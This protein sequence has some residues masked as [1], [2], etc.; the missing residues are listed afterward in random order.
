M[1]SSTI[2]NPSTDSGKD[3]NLA[4]NTTR[5]VSFA[6]LL[7]GEPIRKSINFRTLLAST[8]NG[9]DVSISMEWVRVVHERFSNIPIT[10]FT[11]EGFSAITTKL[12]TPLM[13]DAYTPAL[14]AE[15]WGR[16][17]YARAMVELQVDID[18]KDTLVVR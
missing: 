11:E 8:G 2:V 4:N 17:S 7:K 12:G 18:L 14:C 10:A 3:S 16:L 6:T 5:R 13:L 9:A 15:S 1:V